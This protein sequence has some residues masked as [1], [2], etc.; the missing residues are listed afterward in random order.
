MTQVMGMNMKINALKAGLS[1]SLLLGLLACGGGL[2]EKQNA[3]SVSSLAAS[4][5]MYGREM[6]VSVQGGGLS[7]GVRMVV[8]EGCGEVNS[9][10]TNNEYN[11]GFKCRLTK[12]GSV[13][14]L[15]ED[16]GGKRLASIRVDVPAPQVTIT[17]N[18]GMLKLELDPEKAPLA[19]N[20]FLD[21]VN[22]GFYRNLVFHRV[23]AEEGGILAGAYKTGASLTAV[24][25]LREPI[26]S[27]SNNGLQH[28][29]GSLAMFREGGPDSA[30]SQFFINTRDNPHLNYQSEAQPGYTVFGKLVEGLEVLDTIAAVEVADR[31]LTVNGQSLTLRKVPKVD[32]T[33]L[34]AS[35]TR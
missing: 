16:A 18:K 33:I 13:Q 21:Y 2:D 32:V 30:T 28:L 11:R 8:P 14:A 19:V 23:D 1:C 25:G 15:I 24:T 27:E 29:R 20:N 4:N 22:A 35:Q 12:L 7:D 26:K 34:L 17:T 3:Q 6:V 10:G 5:V 9:T 31:T